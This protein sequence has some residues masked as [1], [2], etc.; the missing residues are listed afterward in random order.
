ML[1][2]LLSLS[3]LF[4]CEVLGHNT[5]KNAFLTL[6]RS[7]PCMTEYKMDEPSGMAVGL[8]SYLRGMWGFCFCSCVPAVV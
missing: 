4:V 3:A 5:R 1:S 8:C 7:Q 2:G 6:T